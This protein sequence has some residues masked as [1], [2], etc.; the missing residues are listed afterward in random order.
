[1]KR[2]SYFVQVTDTKHKSVSAK[3]FK[4]LSR[5]WDAVK[6]GPITFYYVEGIECGRRVEKR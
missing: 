4:E 6:A 3:E 1:M 2:Y 5:H